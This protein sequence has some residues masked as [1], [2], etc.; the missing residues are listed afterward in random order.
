MPGMSQDP[1]NMVTKNLGS[2]ESVWDY[3]T[4][5]PQL[6]RHRNSGRYYTR[7]RVCGVRKMIALRTD[8]WNVARLRHAD[9]LA[10][11]ERQRLMHRRLENG[12]GSMGDLLDKLEQDYQANTALAL[13]SKR[14]FSATIERIV[15]HW[16]RCFGTNLRALRP[17]KITLEKVRR[18]ANY[19]HGEARHQQNQARRSKFGYKA[20]TVNTTVEV[21]YRALRMA[22]ETGMLPSVPFDL[23]PVIGGPL[24]KPEIQ[25][26]LRLPSTA[27]M[28]ELFD[29]MRRV[30]DPLPDNLV[31]MREYLAARRAESAEFAEFMA[32]S[33]AR[34]NEAACFVWED[35]LAESIMLR[36]TKTVSSRNRE[37]PKIAALR[38][39]LHRMRVRREADERPLKG[40]VFDIK[41]C[42]E[43][44][45]TACRNVGIER[46]THHS[47]R[48]FFATICIESGVDI[49]TV[50]RW[51]GHADGGVL[52]MRTYG[53][54]RTE[55]S[56]AAAAKVKLSAVA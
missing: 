14:S 24:R 47:L 15:L 4:G 29:E 5:I 2:K 39:L 1:K 32:Y 31:D 21:L 25:K 49:P 55:H 35:D 42:R 11:A 22:A 12:T 7:T 28:K 17:D 37:V 51:L 43:A 50:S 52:A 30:P 44:L 8:D 18:F 41:E 6:V 46:L 40:R 9:T 56:F 27:K 20:A 23:N 10:K 48:H 54:L 38:E 26:P 36:G 13:K 34:M 3:G 53:H 19:L 16:E 45:A 33:G